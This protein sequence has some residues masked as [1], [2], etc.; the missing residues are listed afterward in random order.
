MVVAVAEKLFYFQWSKTVHDIT[1]DHDDNITIHFTD[2]SQASGT[3]LVGC[4][5]SRSR[6]REKLC[7]RTGESSLN[8]RLDIRLLGASAITPADLGRRLQEMDTYFFQGGDRSSSSFMFWAVQDTPTHNDRKD[9]PDTYAC[10]IIV[11]W[12]YRAGFLGQSKPIEIPTRQEERL[13]LMKQISQSW[14][15]PFRDAV[16]A[17]PA[18]THIQAVNLESWKPAPG[19][20]D[21]L[22]GRATLIGDAA[23]TMYAKQLLSQ[24]IY[25]TVLTLPQDHVPR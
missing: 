9:N 19:K 7:G 20:W 5:G 23:H 18:D 8:H 3:H 14:A 21:N 25:T 6:I 12:P 1:Q 16:Y 13:N 4:D 17:V 24:A 10:Q 2:G 22:N 11:S 15:S